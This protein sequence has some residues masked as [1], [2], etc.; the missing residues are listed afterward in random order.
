MSGMSA[1]VTSDT[2]RW[3]RALTGSLRKSMV[4]TENPP[5]AQGF[6]SGRASPS[7]LREPLVCAFDAG[8]LTEPSDQTLERESR[9]FDDRRHRSS[10]KTDPPDRPAAQRGEHSLIA[11]RFDVGRPTGSGNRWRAGAV[12]RV[13]RPANPRQTL[14][15]GPLYKWGLRWGIQINSEGQ[16][17]GDQN[18]RCKEDLQHI[19]GH[20]QNSC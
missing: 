11:I 18:H 19:F 15:R 12:S 16:I 2:T 17:T 6:V 10:Y 7:P 14:H 13:V 20:S 9:E 3:R 4:V 1:W 5:R 8:P